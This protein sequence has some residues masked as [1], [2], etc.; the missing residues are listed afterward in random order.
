MP[1]ETPE[2]RNYI[3]YLQGKYKDISKT[4]K[5]FKWIWDEGWKTVKSLL[6]QKLK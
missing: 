2:Q 1:S 4:P 6:Q 3:F 5:K